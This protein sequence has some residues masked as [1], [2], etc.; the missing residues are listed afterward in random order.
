M[1]KAA[2]TGYPGRREVRLQV[3]RRV[4][5]RAAAMVLGKHLTRRSRGRC[6]LCEQRDEV[7]VFEL[8]PFPDDPAPERALMACVRCRSWL[9]QG[10]VDVVHAHFLGTAIWSECVPVRTAAARLLATC[11]RQPWI[12]DALEQAGFDAATGQDITPEA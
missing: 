9:E 4:K 5:Q 2:P 11:E 7:R 1:A 6:E 10:G 12:V 8:P 3:A